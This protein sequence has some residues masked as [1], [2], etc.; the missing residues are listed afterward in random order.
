MDYPATGATLH[1]LP[2]DLVAILDEDHAA[3]V[4]SAQIW[5][6]TGSQHEGRWAGAGLSH[7]L[8]HMVFKGTRSFSGPELATRV[9]AA[10]GQWNAYT[11]FDRTV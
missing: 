10:G 8:E 4:V 9:N 1:T 7:L 11:S 6:E 3:P 2:G 5:V